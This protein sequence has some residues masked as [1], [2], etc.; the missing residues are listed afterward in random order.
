MAEEGESG[1]EDRTEAPTPRRL[2]RARESGQ[3]ALSRELSTFASL[4]AAG[5][6]LA[7]AGP[8]ATGR[9]AQH[10][11]GVMAAAH[12]LDVAAGAARA[13]AAGV[14]L[15]LALLLPPLLAGTGTT[16]L[17]TRL[18]ISAK[19]LRPD[20][21]RISPFRGARR[22]VGLDNL[23]ELLKALLK[24]ALLAWA[25]WHVLGGSL[26]TLAGLLDRPPASLGRHTGEGLLRLIFAVLA[27]FALLAGV[28]TLW[29]H[30]RHARK[31]GMTR[32]DLRREVKESEGDPHL[33]AR[34]KQIRQSRAR[35]RMMAAVPKAQVVVTNPTHYAVALAYERGSQAAPVVVAKGTDLVA[36][37]IREAAA[38]AGVPL[39]ANPPLA[40]ALHR[41]PL[42]AAIP[43]EHYRAV[44]EVIAFVWGLSRHA[45]APAAPPVE[46]RTNRVR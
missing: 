30:L 11:A 12:G 10:L 26:G 22:V 32:Q 9:L 44:A 37:R 15:V 14:L 43:P 38:R 29:V 3:V 39:V 31:L 6:G 42:D 45:P 8:Y 41:L 23:V 27:A 19:P 1:G 46:S 5:I 40:R 36:A 33:K 16:L 7:L 13:A 2:E 28:D 18:L 17:Q 24:I 20:P 35:R 21:A 4:L 34:L 25:A